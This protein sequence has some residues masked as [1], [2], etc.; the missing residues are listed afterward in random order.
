RAVKTMALG[1]VELTDDWALRELRI[2]VRNLDDL[3]LYAR[4]LVESLRAA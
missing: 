1:V 2:C 3:G 4:E